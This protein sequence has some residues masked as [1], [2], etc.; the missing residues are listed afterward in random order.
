[1]LVIWQHREDTEFVK[2]MWQGLDD[3]TVLE[4]SNNHHITH[5]EI[6]RALQKEKDMIIFAGHGDNY[7][8]YY[9]DFD[10]HYS[11]GYLIDSSVVQFLRGK[12]VIAIWCYA[13]DFCIRYDLDGF[14][15]SMFIS[16]QTEA[17]HC[18]FS[19]AT[20]EDI[21]HEC[22][23]FFNRIN[24]LL[25]DKIPTSEWVGILQK[26]ADMT[27]PFVRYNYEALCSLPDIDE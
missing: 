27:K 22:D 8:L 13:S 23:L 21:R 9:P 16:E 15:T 24:R 14:S 19:N 18:G 20:Q 12:T 5:S 25:I 11:A 1:M 7:G 6:R 4:C 2:Q 26:Q 10:V 17:V 3:V